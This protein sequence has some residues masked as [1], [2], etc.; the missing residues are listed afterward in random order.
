MGKTKKILILDTE[1][2]GQ[3]P[4][5]ITYDIG[6][7][8]TDRYGTIYHEFHFVVK[9]IFADLEVMATAHYAKKFQNYIGSIYFQYT[10][11][12]PFLDILKKLDAIIELWDIKT[13]AA[14]NLQFDKRA[15]ENTC[16]LFT[17]NRNW[18]G[19]HEVQE[20]CIMCAA[21]DVLYG[22]TYIKMARERGWVTPKGNIRTTA[23]CGYRFISGEP[24]FEE[25]HSGLA[26]SRIEAQILARIYRK[27]TKFD[28]SIRAFPMRQVWALEKELLKKQQ[29]HALKHGLPTME[30]S[31]T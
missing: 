23:E 10:E 25:E 21:C 11:P 7:V 5:Q 4:Q 2:V 15:M 24:D 1:T 9:E 26:D 18:L 6:G 28:G 29:E 27:K 8:V 12:L 19:K 30:S 14:Y 22:Y 20:L 3:I 13:V 31:T 16:E 17:S